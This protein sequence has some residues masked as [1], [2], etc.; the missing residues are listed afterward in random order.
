MAEKIARF[1]EEAANN[2]DVARLEGLMT[3]LKG[4]VFYFI[5]FDNQM[6]LSQF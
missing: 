3:S 5:K 4:S 1:S 6:D 2:K